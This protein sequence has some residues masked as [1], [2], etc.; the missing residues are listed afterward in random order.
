[1]RKVEIQKTAQE[2][3]R[4]AEQ[5]LQRFFPDAIDA[6]VVGSAARRDS[7]PN[8][9]DIMIVLPDGRLPEQEEEY[10]VSDIFY[11]YWSRPHTQLPSSLI[12]TRPFSFANLEEF[13]EWKGW[14]IDL[15][16]VTPQRLVEYVQAFDPRLHMP[17]AIWAMGQPTVEI[18]NARNGLLKKNLTPLLRR[19]IGR[20]DEPEFRERLDELK[21]NIFDAQEKL[22]ISDNYW[23]DKNTLNQELKGKMLQFMHDSLGLWRHDPTRM[24]DFVSS[25]IAGYFSWQ[26]GVTSVQA[27]TDGSDATPDDYD[28]ILNRY[29]PV[30]QSIREGKISLYLNVNPSAD[31]EGDF[32]ANESF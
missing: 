9:I 4:T 12:K 1:M 32:L 27:Y 14:K 8:D 26:V 16:A 28:E 20:L 19:G 25:E 23:L 21:K 7:T 3:V 10:P 22:K 2:A 15:L 6:L 13:I 29:L 24:K 5:F 31:F 30:I 11:Q 17:A 18:G